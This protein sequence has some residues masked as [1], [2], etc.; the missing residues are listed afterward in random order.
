MVST[1]VAQSS[2]TKSPAALKSTSTSQTHK[3]VTPV[4]STSSGKSTKKKPV[5]S[6]RTARAKMQMAPTADR[7]KEIQSA[8]A[9]SESYK[10]E[11]TGKWDDSSV[12]AMKHFQQVNGLNPSGKLDALSLQKLGLGSDTAGRG[13]PRIVKPPSSSPA[14][15]TPSIQR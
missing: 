15:T 2:S 7:I 1:A 9:A 10:G 4:K 6:A 8:L 3:A 5:A 13:A 11:P 14:S 12:A